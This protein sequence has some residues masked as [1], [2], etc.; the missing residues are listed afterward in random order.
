MRLHRFFIIACVM[1]FL[2]PTLCHG[3]WWPFSMYIL[4]PWL[5]TRKTPYFL[6]F[7]DFLCHSGVPLAC[8][9]SGDTLRSNVIY[10]LHALVCKPQTTFF[11]L[12]ANTRLSFVSCSTC[13]AFC[14][15]CSIDLLFF[16]SC[17]LML[18]FYSIICADISL[19]LILFTTNYLL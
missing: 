15:F 4:N 10:Y 12:H 6:S 17:L 14:I 2:Q 3:Y 9:F 11:T 16:I 1:P 7:C 8:D 19:L 5:Q 18:H 13:D